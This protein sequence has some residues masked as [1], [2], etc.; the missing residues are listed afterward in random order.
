MHTCRHPGTSSIIVGTEVHCTGFVKRRTY[1]VA[2]VD[3]T[4]C[5]T[6]IIIRNITNI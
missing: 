3:T 2:V 5:R 1:T 4:G 6:V